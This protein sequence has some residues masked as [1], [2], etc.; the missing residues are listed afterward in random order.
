MKFI[1]RNKPN[2]NTG[3]LCPTCFSIGGNKRIASGIQMQQA[4]IIFV[5]SGYSG[6]LYLELRTASKRAS[7]RI[8]HKGRS[9]TV[10]PI[11]KR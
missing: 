4:E 2:L 8:S 5:T 7:I 3:M 10:G 6:E 9:I 1:I 11:E